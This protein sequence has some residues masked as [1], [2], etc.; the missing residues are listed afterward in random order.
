MDT[1][2][3][4]ASALP[5]AS[6][7]SAGVDATLDVRTGFVEVVEKQMFSPADRLALAMQG[8]T[9]GRLMK[10]ILGVY[11]GNVVYVPSNIPKGLKVGDHVT[12]DQVQGGSLR[13]DGMIVCEARFV[14]S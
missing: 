1:Q 11:D 3:I 6:L 8:S 2:A 4:V 9:T 10:H 5:D 12:I 14:V 7:V 13:A